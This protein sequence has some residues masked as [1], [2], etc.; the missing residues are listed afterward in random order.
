M[1]IHKN[2]KH[3]SK[4][5]ENNY[6]LQTAEK[7]RR[8]SLIYYVSLSAL[9]IYTMT[10]HFL[11]MRSLA[12][13]DTSQLINYVKSFDFLF[14]S[15]LVLLLNIIAYILIKRMLQI[16]NTTPL[17]YVKDIRELNKYTIKNENPFIAIEEK[18]NIVFKNVKIKKGE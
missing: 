2:Y 13:N 9:L 3:F 15:A 1:N 18:G 14:Q 10:Y 5:E 16:K 17:N 11:H 8:M 6:I 7:E 4:R 12:Y